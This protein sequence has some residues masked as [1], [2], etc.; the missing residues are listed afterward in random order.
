MTAPTEATEA[1]DAVGLAR[2]KKEALAK[3]VG[4]DGL[5]SRIKSAEERQVAK[6]TGALQNR[7]C[8]AP[9]SI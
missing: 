2:E 8:S 4:I 9:V 7:S 5:K 3:K 1:E 6:I